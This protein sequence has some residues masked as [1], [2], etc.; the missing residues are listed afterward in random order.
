MPFM[1]SAVEALD[2]P[3]LMSSSYAHAYLKTY[4]SHMHIT[5]SKRVLLAFLFCIS[6]DQEYANDYMPKSVIR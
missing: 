2:I 4:F 5:V 3:D 1:A 6:N